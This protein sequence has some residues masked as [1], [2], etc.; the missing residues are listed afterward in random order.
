MQSFPV[1]CFDL[2]LTQHLS[3]GAELQQLHLEEMSTAC[4]Q[5]HWY[6]MRKAKRQDL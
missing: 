2:T 3:E 5:N 4:P 6:L 1:Q